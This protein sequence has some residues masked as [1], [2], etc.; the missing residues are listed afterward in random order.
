MQK[1]IFG[2][3]NSIKYSCIYIGTA[4]EP[5]KE[6]KEE[7]NHPQMSKTSYRDDITAFQELMGFSSLFLLKIPF[8]IE[9]FLLEASL[10]DCTWGRLTRQTKYS[11]DFFV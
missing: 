3:D 4:T 1:V 5:F 6:G 10:G 11:Y 9:L 7:K 2:Y 8:S